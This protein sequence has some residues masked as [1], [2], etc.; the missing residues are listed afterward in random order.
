[1]RLAARRGSCQSGLKDAKC[2]SV[3]HII[4]LL[5]AVPAFAANP[6]TEIK[7]DQAGYLSGSPKVAF[8]ASKAAATGF[9]VR[10]AKDGK[11]AFSGKLTAPADDPDSGDRVQAADFTKLAK[12]GTFYLDVPGVGRSWD[13]SIGPDVYA[14]AWYM[15]MRSFYGQRCG[16]AVDLG[17]EFPGYKHDACHLEAAYHASSGKN[18][19]LLNLGGWHDAGDY[20]RYVVNSG[21]STGTLLW[22]WEMFGSRLQNVKL[23]LPESGNGTPDI[24]NEIRWNLD[25]MLTMQDQDG[26]VWH[27]QTSE[28][29]CGFIMPEADKLVSY[30]IGIGKEP[31]KSSCATGDF[32]AVMAIASRV[33]RPFNAAFA[34]KCL[35]AARQAFAWLETNPGVMFENSA[36]VS[37]GGYGDRNC[38]DE[39]LWAAAELGRTTGDEIYQRYFLEH[40]AEYRSS[41]RPAGPQSWANV[42]NLALWT[43]ALGRGKNAEALA[44]IRQDS[45]AAADQIAARTTAN[46]YRISMTARD[47]IWGSNSV[48]A[49]YG[50]QLLVANA[51]QPNASY[52]EAAL[53]NLHYLLGRNTFSLSFVTQVGANPF[54][55]PHHRPSGADNNPEP[56]P[57]LLSGGP[58]RGRQD[59]AMR[60]LPAD[61][62]PAKMY[63]DD[64]EAYSANEVAIN[65]NA[66]LVF[67][68][69]GTLAAK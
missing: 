59:P 56:W 6:I 30:I 4:A 28:K 36:G 42:A 37:T 48:A 38:G 64:Q 62:P 25:W 35:R 39:H 9:T 27:K 67:L 31:Y 15:T 57:G 50:M 60:K 5:I 29:F 13:F 1:M 22:T 44:A 58:N 55:H 12:S 16:I 26:G 18:G 14:R 33:Y 41:V 32:A 7:V 24:L 2:G 51:L 61:L 45:A 68:L 69:A 63:L 20:G 17:P 53:E 47:Y 43:Y 21:I 8:V 52:V 19:R 3:R 11:V 65:W 10:A 54:R 49:N 34:E 66:P 40:Y 23:N 46:P